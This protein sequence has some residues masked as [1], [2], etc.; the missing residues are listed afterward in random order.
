MK[1]VSVIAILL[2]VLVPVV[3]GAADLGKRDIFKLGEA[4]K[5]SDNEVMVPISV[6]HDEG[7]VAMD[8][9][10]EWTAGV[11]LTEVSFAETRVDYFDIKIANIDE[12][13]NRVLIG[14]IS[15]VFGPKD[16][17]PAGEGVIANLK[18]RVD[19]PDI[20]DFE[21]TPFTTTNPGH[22]LSLVY[23]DL[24]SGKPR[25]AHVNPEVTGNPIDLVGAKSNPEAEPPLPTH[26]NLAQ[27]FPNPFNPSTTVAYSLKDAGRVTINIFNVLGQNVKTLVDE[28]QAAGEYTAI[29]DG[30]D[31]DGNSVGTGV[32][33][34]R[35]K[36]GDFSD[37][38][39]MVLMK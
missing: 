21:V 38:K 27:N 3:V 18:F 5:I 16:E 29:W 15:M 34:Y 37:I 12:E 23:N 13:N 8:I 1:R 30:H 31:D 35:I 7:I 20:T 22:S 9:P 14:L 10:L 32:Y 28:Y 39:K 17:L 26:Y 25:V 11:T 33:F 4:T 24:S 2:C 36:A 19:N 6:T